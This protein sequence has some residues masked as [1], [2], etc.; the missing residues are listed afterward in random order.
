MD[1]QHFHT[2]PHSPKSGET[3]V[4]KFGL[5]SGVLLA[6]MPF[7]VLPS[8]YFNRSFCQLVNAE[9]EPK[10]QSSDTWKTAPSIL[11]AQRVS[12]CTHGHSIK[13]AATHSRRLAHEHLYRYSSSIA[14]QPMR[15]IINHIPHAWSA[16]QRH[17]YSCGFSGCFYVKAVAKQLR[18]DGQKPVWNCSDGR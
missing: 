14:L 13:A 4:A 16:C 2:H 8:I 6:S 15:Q 9:T 7:I 3:P 11:L 10:V 17:T 5:R 12:P 1:E 18:Q